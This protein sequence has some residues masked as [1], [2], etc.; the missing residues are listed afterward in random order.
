MSGGNAL[1]K[2][3]QID[4]GQENELWSTLSHSVCL[5]TG[6][7]KTALEGFMGSEYSVESFQCFLKTEDKY[8]QEARVIKNVTA[9]FVFKGV[10]KQA[11]DQ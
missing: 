11:R 8:S 7:L 5:A 6:E 9:D 4:E 3:Q 1:E 10:A 2:R